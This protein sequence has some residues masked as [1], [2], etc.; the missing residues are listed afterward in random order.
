M[1][2]Q[3]LG[4][5]GLRLK[6]LYFYNKGGN[7]HSPFEVHVHLLYE[8]L[9][10]GRRGSYDLIGPGEMKEMVVGVEG[11]SAPECVVPD[12]GR[13]GFEGVPSV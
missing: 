13:L 8:H 10:R 7:L 3:D 6:E 11:E 5:I 12:G 9:C 1:S 2:R 4:V